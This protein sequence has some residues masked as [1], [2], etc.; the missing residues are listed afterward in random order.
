MKGIKVNRFGDENVLAY[1]DIPLPEPECGE[2][3]IKMYAAGVNPVDTYIRSGNYYPLPKLP[4]TPGNDGAGVIDSVGEGVHDFKRGDRVFI[5]AALA[6][7]NT[8]TYAEM[9]VC[10]ANAVR[11]LPEKITFSQG[12]GIGTPGLAAAD[13]LF[14]RARICHGEIVMVN[15]ASGGVGTLAV[16]LARQRGAYVIGVAGSAEGL[17]L[18]RELGA[19]DTFDY[20]SKTLAD[21]ILGATAGKGP[22]VIVELAA[23]INLSD[24]MKIISRRGR[25]VV[26]GSGGSLVFDPR[27]TMKKDAAV[28]GMGL[29]NMRESEYISN[30][31]AISA[32]LENGMQVAV[33]EEL[34]LESAAR[35]HKEV[36]KPSKNG[37]IVLVMNN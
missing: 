36:G 14:T 32:A 27:L 11:P 20:H 17:G 23:H 33:S 37:K 31:Y 24:D 18:A 29:G 2:V 35:A 12:S 4:Y 9:T 15:G 10:D 22:D 1:T 21:D 34:S 13:A 16:Q 8:G 3:R 19:H 5:A 30:M 26:I 28:L 25:V 6:K 7:R